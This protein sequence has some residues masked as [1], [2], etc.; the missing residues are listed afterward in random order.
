[1]RIDACSLTVVSWL[2]Q[3]GP[4]SLEIL[5]CEQ[6]LLEFSEHDIINSL[7]WLSSHHLIEP[8]HCDVSMAPYQLFPGYVDYS[9]AYWR[10]SELGAIVRWH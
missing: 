4:L 6:L 9:E 5:V 2:Q 1:M 10:L 8:Y 3:S 7:D